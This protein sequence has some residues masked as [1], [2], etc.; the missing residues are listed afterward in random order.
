MFFI[1]FYHDLPTNL[2][3]FQKFGF[4]DVITSRLSCFGRGPAKPCGE[5]W[6]DALNFLAPSA[7]PAQKQFRRLLRLLIRL[8]LNLNKVIVLHLFRTLGARGFSCVVSGF[9]QVL[10]SDPR[11]FATRVF[12]LRPNTC[13][14][15]A[16][17]TKLP[18]AREKKPLVP[19]VPFP[20]I[21]DICPLKCPAKSNPDF[22][23]FELSSRANS[24]FIMARLQTPSSGLSA[25]HSW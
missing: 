10:K 8:P 4:C 3:Q 21:S 17:E 5:W 16:D 12:D 18:V 19:R 22:K 11:G 9:D 2:I 24:E 14:P 7:P 23:G 20:L 6:G 15:A 25:A 13:R 1:L